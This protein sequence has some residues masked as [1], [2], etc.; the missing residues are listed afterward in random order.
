MVALALGHRWAG[1][2]SSR[3]GAVA[4]G[5]GPD[6]LDGR[7]A[8]AARA[9]RRGPRGAA[10]CR[11]RRP[12]PQ[13]RPATRVVMVLLEG[14]SLDVIA[15]AAA[16]G[17]L[18]HFERL[19]DARRVA[20][21]RD[22]PADAAGTGVDAARHRQ[23]AV[24]ERHPLG[25]ARTRRWPSDEALEVLPDYCFSHALVRVRLPARAAARQ[26]RPDR[27]AALEPARRPRACRSA[28][29]N[30]SV[31][32]PA[33]DVRGYLV[34]DRFER[35]QDVG[36]RRR[37]HRARLAARGAARGGR[38]GGG[39]GAARAGRAARAAGRRRRELIA[40]PCA[41]RSRARAD[42]GRARRAAT[43]AASRPCATNASTRSATTS[44]GTPCPGPS[45]TCR[46]RSCSATAAS[47][48]PTTP[49]RTR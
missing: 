14:A 18:P 38:G 23:A 5:R 12:V 43:R 21:P 11:R 46:T 25:G 10:R 41:R 28:S 20:A 24:Q 44:S 6:G 2:H 1:R 8:D 37:E 13:A 17:R 35:R 9:R 32:Q 34:S 29:S 16:E 45:A 26:P 7:A 19:L 39:P 42:R 4:A 40:R 33:R 36:G 30:W 47:W 48:R 31:T 22:D 49:R 15:P 27:A 3:P